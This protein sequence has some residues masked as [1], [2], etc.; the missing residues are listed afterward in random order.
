MTSCA[1][2][3]T[4]P[5]Q[6]KLR[7]AL[8]SLTILAG[9]ALLPAL[10]ARAQTF[11]VLHSFTGGIDGANPYNGVTTDQFGHLFAPTAQGGM[12]HPD[13]GSAFELTSRGSGLTFTPIY[14]FYT[15]FSG[16]QPESAVVVGRGGL[17][18]GTTNSYSGGAG[19][20]YSLQPPS[21]PVCHS[22]ACYWHGTPLYIFAGE[23][24]GGDPGTATLTL[25]AAGNLYGVTQAGGLNNSGVVYELSHS[26]GGWS[27]TVLYNMPQMSSPV[28]SGVIF[29]SAGNLYG[30]TK[31]SIYELSPSGS[32]WTETTLHT[33]SNDGGINPYG[34]LIFDQ[35]GNL[36]GT[37][38]MDGPNGG[39]TVFELSPSNGGWTF[40]VLYAFSGPLGPH[41]GVVMDSAGNLYGTTYE[42]GAHNDGL[43]YKLTHTEQGWMFTD[44]HD[45]TAGEDGSL[46]MG[47]LFVDASGNIIGTTLEGGLSGCIHIGSCG[48]LWEITP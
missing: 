39:G 17:L 16:F 27:E 13:V 23:S 2:L 12:G 38:S 35:A 45:F 8:C 5:S 1:R 36:Y 43:V 31:Q 11:T 4:L 14:E 42:D 10:P 40:S 46:P 3:S 25:D 30:Q 33:W 24:D 22:L 7:Q 48:V 15:D 47:K 29:D 20:V 6:T 9:L 18:Y 19:T 28:N 26:G 32:G 37:T 21:T 44:L 41:G 34:E